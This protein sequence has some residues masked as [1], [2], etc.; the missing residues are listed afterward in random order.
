VI[1]LRSVYPDRVDIPGA[2]AQLRGAFPSTAIFQGTHFKFVQHK[3]V[4]L[5]ETKR[6]GRF[7]YWLLCD[8]NVKLV[9]ASISSK[10]EPLRPLGELVSNL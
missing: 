7:F 2:L 5:L 10:L 8:G 4:W 9:H 3:D 6:S 1:R